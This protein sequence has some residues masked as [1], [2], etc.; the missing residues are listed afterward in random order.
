MIATGPIISQ[1]CELN[2]PRFELDKVEFTC[3]TPGSSLDKAGLGIEH[4]HLIASFTAWGEQGTTE[5]LVV[6]TR[7]GETIIS[8]D[9]EF[10]DEEQLAELLEKAM[11]D[12]QTMLTDSF[13]YDRTPD[14]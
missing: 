7:S 4:R 2:L 11:H 14:K 5:W 12:L 1:W 9:E 10:A 3:M 8:R 6:D 13:P